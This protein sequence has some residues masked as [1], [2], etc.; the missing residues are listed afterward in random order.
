MY[1]VSA[2]INNVNIIKVDLD[3]N[4]QIDI[5]KVK[6]QFDDLTKIIFITNPN[7]PTGN[8]FNEDSIIEIIKSF[9]RYRIY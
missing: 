2:K 8:C 3:H 5:E 7:N 1:E 6:S 9:K 4:F